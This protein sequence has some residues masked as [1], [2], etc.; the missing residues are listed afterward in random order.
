[1]RRRLLAVA[2]VGLV[3]VAV[4]AVARCRDRVDGS[5]AAATATPRAGDDPQRAR[6]EAIAARRRGLPPE[7]PRHPLR[8]RVVDGDDRPV[9]GVAVVLAPDG[10]IATS[11]DD[12]AFAFERL[13]PGPYAVEARAG[14]RVGGPVRVVLGAATAPVTLRLYRGA[15]GEVEVVAAD[16]GAPVAGAEVAIHQLSMYPGAGAQ[17]ARTDA[18]G[19]ARF[20]G[21]TLVAHD[22]LAHAPGFAPAADT[23]D[24]TAHAGGAWRLRLALD[25]GATVTGRVVD[26]AGAP[27][28]GA[29]IEVHEGGG[30]DDSP[31]Q[32]EPD[33]LGAAH[34]VL[35]QRRGD[36]ARTDAEGRFAVALAAGRWAITATADG[37]EPAVSPTLV[38]DGRTAGDGLTLVLGRGRSVRGVVVDAADAPVPGAA[39]EVRWSFGSRVE[40]R[41]RADGTGRFELTG[42]PPGK[43]AVIALAEGATSSPAHVD[44]SGGAPEEDLILALAHTGTITGVVRDVAGRPVRDAQVFHVEIAR[45]EQGTHV[46]PSVVTGDAEGRF[47]IAGVAAG[48]AYALTAMRPQDGDHHFRQA[49]ATAR[50][51]EHVELVVPADGTVHG[52]VS[53]AGARPPAGT[54]VELEGALAPA[55]VGADGRFRLGPLPPGARTLVVAGRGLPRHAVAIEVP[56]GELDLGTIEVPKGRAIAGRV[57]RGDGRGVAGVEVELSGAAGAAIRAITDEGGRFEATAPAGVAL[58][59]RARHR[60]G[61]ISDAAA[62][63]PDG[64]ATRVVLRLGEGATIE[65]DARRGDQPLRDAYVVVRRPDSRDDAPLTYTQTDD[66]GYFRLKGVPAGEY[67]VEL[68]V[69]DPARPEPTLVPE[70]VAVADGK[71][72]FVS[73]EVP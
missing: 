58:E 51:G 62:I 29:T 47:T 42:L 5:R 54:T 68:H 6:R 35:A 26:D 59:A 12:G 56:S 14:A 69:V 22:V 44:L 19:V 41:G 61:R 30:D 25:A 73:F 9:A 49:G 17:R 3:A 39:I 20:E 60:A 2:V 48:R 27:V 7:A 64:D 21:L 52:T 38:S 36:G 15:I 72:A 45:S 33:R 70:R 34:P 16:G 37:H 24:P 63:P 18:R 4:L 40:R 71:T 50:A 1:M 32:L 23:L 43:L 13:P 57:E 55:R 65:G 66:A 28:A 10:A 31:R 8:G 46:H 53:V 11:D 67:V